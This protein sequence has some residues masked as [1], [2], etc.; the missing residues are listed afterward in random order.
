[1]GW[2]WMA[3]L[4]VL[5]KGLNK[6]GAVMSSQRLHIGVLIAGMIFIAGCPM[7][8]G[9]EGDI[10]GGN[11]SGVADSNENGNDMTDSGTIDGPV[12]S[13]LIG[14]WNLFDYVD[15]EQVS[16]IEYAQGSSDT[17]IVCTTLNSDGDPKLDD[18]GQPVNDVLLAIQPGGTPTDFEVF[19]GSFSFRYVISG[20]TNNQFEL[21]YLRSETEEEPVFRGER[22]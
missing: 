2:G 11:G 3:A 4:A 17:R 15:G 8:G 6:I 14:R 16:V 18:L 20:G 21:R 19:D 22:R 7:D 10:T 13:L 1:M 9:S 5:K 12:G